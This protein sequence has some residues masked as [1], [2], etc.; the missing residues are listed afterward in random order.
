MASQ[1]ITTR[2]GLTPDEDRLPYTIKTSDVESYLQ[3]KIDVVLN[4]IALNNHSQPEKIDIRVYTTEAGKSFL[5][6]VVILPMEALE[7]KRV[8]KQSQMA[9]IFDTKGN[10][11]TANLKRPIYEVL[12]AYIFNKQDGEVFKSDSWR[13]EH[14]VNRQATP[15]LLSMRTP[16]VVQIE[17]GKTK[18]VE[19]MIDPARIFHDMLKTEKDN[20]QYRINIK[21]WQKIQVGEF[22]Y[23][24]E[25][26]L[27]K[28][29]KNKKYKST[30]ADELNRKMKGFR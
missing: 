23:K 24:V 26:V 5:P 16:K 29:G 6:F 18:V 7:D 19:L 8:K 9:S 15:V 2:S 22:S 12:S 1:E 10:E 28:G 20:R 25:R 17:G 27:N 3:R 21:S 11:G 13:R 4:R 14:H 30:L